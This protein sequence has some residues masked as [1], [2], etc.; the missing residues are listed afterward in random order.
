MINEDEI[1]DDS[2]EE[3]WE[4]VK[5][6][7]EEVTACLFCELKFSSIEKAIP[8][9]DQVHQFNLRSLKEK[10]SMDFYSY[11][12]VWIFGHSL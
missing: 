8:H 9:L 7:D 2:D 3:K 12:K 11:I 4:E 10:Y 6:E 1:S 5:D